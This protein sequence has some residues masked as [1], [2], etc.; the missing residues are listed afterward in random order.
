MKSIELQGLA[1]R[2]VAGDRQ[3][4][5]QAITRAESTRSDDRQTTAALLSCFG[6]VTER[7]TRVAISGVPGVG[8]STFI[9]ALGCH[10]VAS[11]HRPAVLTIDPSSARS[12]GSI[13]GDKTRM[14]SLSQCREAYIRPSP[15]SGVLGGV[16]RHTR[17]T[18]RLC[19]AAGFDVILVETVGVGQSEYVVSSMT[20]VFLLMLL[21]A[22]GDELQGIKRGITELADVVM[23]NKA[24]GELESTARHT[25]VDYANAIRL[26][27]PRS[28]SWTVPVEAGS[29][30][31]RQG[32]DRIW[33]HIMRCASVLDTTG[34][35]Q[36]RRAEQSL[37]WMWDDTMET[38]KTKLDSDVSLRPMVADLKSQVSNGELTPTGAAEKLVNAFLNWRD[39]S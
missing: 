34:E 24:D 31:H 35:L 13:L 38:L 26:H 29:A 3:A 5:A 21:P 2:L 16:G 36:A 1:E 33:S 20:D 10:I 7:S 8:K 32:V 25:A 27:K 6:A 18:I 17:E 22:G 12:G 37:T 11:G 4:L 19:E 15:T 14:P 28:S 9:D 30:L 39:R 23:I